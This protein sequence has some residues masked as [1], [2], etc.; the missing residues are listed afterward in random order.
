VIDEREKHVK[1]KIKASVENGIHTKTDR[2]ALLDLLLDLQR[3]GVMSR[4]DVR[5]Q[6]DTFI[7]EVGKNRF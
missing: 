2:L 4:R 5:E 1:L 7:F 6:V 3:R